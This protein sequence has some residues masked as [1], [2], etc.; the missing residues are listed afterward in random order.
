MN[1]GIKY[2]T[3]LAQFNYVTRAMIIN[4]ID[5]QYRIAIQSKTISNMAY[6]QL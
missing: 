5:S 3:I 6:I 1:D 4:R 2:L